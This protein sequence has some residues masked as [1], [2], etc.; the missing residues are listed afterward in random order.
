M[1]VYQ[2]NDP[3]RQNIDNYPKTYDRRQVMF[4]GRGGDGANAVGMPFVLSYHAVRH[5]SA[6]QTRITHPERQGNKK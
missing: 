2:P 3:S 1:V 5:K 4:G 6:D